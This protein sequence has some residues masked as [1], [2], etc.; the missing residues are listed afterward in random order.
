M[1]HLSIILLSA[2]CLSS[3]GGSNERKESEQVEQSEQIKQ[4]S[5]HDCVYVCTGCSAKR[6]HS[7][8]F[9]EGLSS[10]GGDILE[11]SIDEAVNHGRTPCRMCV[12]K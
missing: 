12:R 2:I 8:E 3:C 7:V 9:C 10:C 11:M 6:Y 1:K 4:E 5:P